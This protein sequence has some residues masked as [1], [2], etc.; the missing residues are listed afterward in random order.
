MPQQK[1][2]VQRKAVYKISKSLSWKPKQAV[3]IRIN[4]IGQAVQVQVHEALSSDWAP[5]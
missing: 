5:I 4:S 1:L 3:F 2:I